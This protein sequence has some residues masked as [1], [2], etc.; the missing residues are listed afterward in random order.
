MWNKSWIVIFGP[1]FLLVCEIGKLKPY[2]KTSTCLILSPIALETATAALKLTLT[3]TPN[4]AQSPPSQSR[5]MTSL[6]S[7]GLFA[8]FLTTASTTS[9]IAYKIYKTSRKSYTDAPETFTR[10]IKVLFESA[11]AY[12][13]VI[14]IIAITSVIPDSE[15]MIHSP[16][17]YAV[18]SYLGGITAFVSVG[19]DSHRDGMLPL[20]WVTVSNTLL[21]QGIAPTILVARIVM[22]DTDSDAVNTSEVAPYVSKSRTRLS[23]LRF[24]NRTSFM[25]DNIFGTESWDDTISRASQV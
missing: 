19:F 5:L 1:L 20:S 18:Q 14:L 13:V 8:A 25:Q 16:T 2:I 11:S 23:A 12:S 9:L 3:T 10:I 15:D 21:L 22:S 4:L 7:S 17:I 24:H 6:G